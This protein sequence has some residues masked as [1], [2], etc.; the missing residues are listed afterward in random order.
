[1]P[2][3]PTRKRGKMRGTPTER[4]LIR[5]AHEE[6]R[7]RVE[8]W[9]GTKPPERDVLGFF[10]GGLVARGIGRTLMRGA[11]RTGAR[12]AARGAARVGTRKGMLAAKQ[13]ARRKAMLAKRAALRTGTKTAG[14]S[15]AVG[16]QTAA[17]AAQAAKG[18]GL[19]RQALSTAAAMT[20]VDYSMQKLLGGPEMP[21]MP[22][23]AGYGDQR[24]QELE[25]AAARA[26]ATP[27]AP[28]MDYRGLAGARPRMGEM[29][30]TIKY[31]LA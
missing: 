16:T 24:D 30:G 17:K 20:A 11:A 5:A 4:K 8:A 13:A 9:S 26:E 15:A 3:T 10:I 21:E 28:K 29:V 31:P 12:T 1:V 14:K 18:P 6:A 22:F 23:E 7:K 19:F 2:G 27:R 25:D